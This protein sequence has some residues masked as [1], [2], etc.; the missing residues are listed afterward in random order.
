MAT[1]ALELDISHK[2]TDDMYL[3]IFC[4]IW[5]DAGANA[6]DIRDTEQNLRS[7]I[8]RFKKFQD[9]R[10][11]QKF[12]E[13]RSQ[14]ER[15]VII[16]SGQLGREIV[17][18][19]HKLRQVISI[20]VYCMDKE[21]NKKW[22]DKF[23]KV[24]AVVVELNQLISR[25]KADHKIQKIVEEPLSINIFTASSGAGTSTMGVNGQFVFYQVFIDCILRLKSTEKDKEELINVCKQQYQGNSIELSNLRN[26]QEDYSPEKVLW[27]YTKESFFYKTLN[28]ALRNQDVHLIFL[29]RAFIFDIHCQLKNDQVKHPK[30][31]YRSQ[32]VSNNELKILKQCCGQFISINSFFSTSTDRQQA[33][34]FL[35]I[36]EAT[37]NLKPVLF[38]IDAD[39]S[40]VT[41]KPFADISS[42]SEYPGESEI[43]FML[44]SIFRLNSIKQ[45]SDDQVSII[46]MRLCSD[47]VNT[48][49]EVLVH[50]KKQLGSGETDLQTLGKLLWDL[51]KLDLAE[52][53][54]LRWLEQRPPN[55]ALL[56]ELYKNLGNV[57]SQ[58]GKTEDSMKWWKKAVE[59]EN[60]KPREVSVPTSKCIETKLYHIDTTI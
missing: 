1:P 7:I 2:N 22:A 52:K 27:W 55:D 20:Y 54:F 41:S 21:G 18:S 43:L 6:K 56:G 5:L 53:Y 17:P 44:C 11:C 28:A 46:G 42:H 36:S 3:E 51:G 32:M 19:I 58:V 45:N 39:P 29:F 8:N 49:K 47:D 40:V 48:L 31:V 9:V 24:K 57:T 59:L 33:L 13:E 34:S 30:L 12:I 4:L 16:V 26:F 23:A 10:Q 38:E 25:I 37:D 15:V 60:Q 14:K 50:M 35:N